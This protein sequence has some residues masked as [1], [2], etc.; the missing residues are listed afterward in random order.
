M[1]VFGLFDYLTNTIMLPVGG[2]L[3]VVFGAFAIGFERIKT[4]LL[5]SGQKMKVG[6]YWKPV[7][8]WVIPLAVL[9]ILL[10]G[11]FG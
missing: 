1:T 8:K 3:I 5:A 9:V 10:N 2:L 7:I 4:H 11:L 6:E